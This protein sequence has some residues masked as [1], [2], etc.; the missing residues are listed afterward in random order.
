MDFTP[1]A[2]VQSLLEPV[3]KL[4]REQLL[5]LEPLLLA[6]QY[7]ELMVE[8]DK[9][10]RVVKQQGLWAPHLPASVGGMGLSLLEFAQLSQCLGYSPLGH[11]AFGCQAPDA[12]NAELL[13]HA[14]SDAQKDRYLQPLALG[15]IRSCFAMTERHLAGSN[16][17][18]MESRAELDGEHW[19]INAHKWFT[20]AAQGA[21]FAIVMAKTD[22]DAPKHKQASMFLVPM[23]TQGV[24]RVRNIS[25]MGS[26]GHGPFS[27]AEMKFEQVRV[28]KTALIGERGQGFALAQSRLGPGRIHHCMRWL[29]LAER[30]LH[31]TRDYLS[32]RMVSAELSLAQQPVAQAML[33]RAWAQYESARWLVL[34]TA[35]QVDQQ[36]FTDAKAAISMIKFQTAQMLQQVVDMAVQLHGGLGVTDDTV[37]A[38]IYREERAARIYDGPDEV[39]Q[40]SAAKQLIRQ[41]M[42]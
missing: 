35:W 22:A 17:T 21:E 29:G 10:R 8:I 5:P 4:V 3:Q 30:A 31:Q 42:A 19:L 14:G 9:V 37:L 28:P 40:L 7:S 26:S 34:H 18:L 20:T 16:P 1:S 6:H 38:F 36:N 24:S 23:D 32:R 15:E 27:H 13:L 33:A 41:G 2:R 25:V 12:G 39:H 11:L